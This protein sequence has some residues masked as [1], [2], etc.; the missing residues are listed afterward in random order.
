MIRKLIL[1]AIMLLV[2]IPV[3]A[4]SEDTAWVRIY[5]GPPHA[6]YIANAIAVD[7]SGNAFVTGYSTGSETSGDYLTVKYDMAGNELWVR[8]YHGPGD[9][10]DGARCIALDDSGNVY[11]SGHSYGVDVSY[12]YATIKYDAEGN[13]IWLRRY[14][15]PGNSVDRALALATDRFGNVYVTGASYDGTSKFDYATIKYYPNGDTA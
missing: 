11:V 3:F 7:G 5:D 10:V 13:E 8:R 2:S 6:G 14:N 1:L 4:Q 12:D 15:G 9:W